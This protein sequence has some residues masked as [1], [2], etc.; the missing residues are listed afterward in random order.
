M[1]RLRLIIHGQVQ[2]VSYRY[3]VSEKAKALGV[4]GYVKNLPDSTVEVV[5]EGEEEKLKELAAECEKGPA[6]A[7]VQKVEA[8]WS[9]FT[10]QHTS[11]HMLY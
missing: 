7:T 5:A 6:F 10:N 1:K 11:F 4:T 2:G 3:F 9:G 8:E